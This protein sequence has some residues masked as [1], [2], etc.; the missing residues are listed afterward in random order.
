[1]HETLRARQVAYGVAGQATGVSILLR[2]PLWPVIGDHAPFMTFFPAVMLSA[3]LGG[4]GPGLVATF[5]SAAASAFF[6]PKPHFS[7]EVDDP[8]DV[9]A[10]GL[11]TLTGVV[12]SALSESLHRSRRRI[13]ASERRYAVTLASIGDAVLA[14]DAQA[15]VTFLNPTAEALTGWPLADAVGRPLAEVFRIVNEQTR[16]PVEDPAAKVFRTGAAVGLA[17]HTALLARDGRVTPIDDCAAPII[18]ERGG[19]GG[20]VLVFRDVTRR[21]RAEEAEVFRAAYERL[22][23]AVRGSNVGVWDLELPDGDYNR[24][25]RL[26]VNIWEQLGYDGPPPGR[27]SALDKADPDDRAHLEDTVRRYLAGETAEFEG[28]NRLRHKDGSYRTMLARGTAVRDA[29]GKPIRIA[30]VIIDITTLKLTEEALRASEQRF[31]T[32]VDHAADAF[33]LFDDQNIVLD[34][35]RQACE[36]LGRTRDELLG[37]TPIDFDPDVTPAQLEAMNHKLNDGQL[38]TFES[39]HRRKDGTVFPVEV[40]GQAFWEGGRRFTVSLARDNTER[41]RAEE[42]LRVSEAQYRSLADL[43]PGVVW[44]AEPDGAVDYAN[45]FW[46]RYTGL[47]PEQTWG[48]GWGAALHPDDLR[49]VGDLWT[50]ALRTGEPIGVEYRVRRASDGAYRWFLAWGTPVRDRDG[51]VVKWFGTGTDIDDQKRAEAELRDSQERFRGTFENAAVGIAHVD[52]AGRF[53]R[54]NEK[55]CA[56][57]GYSREELFQRTYQ[58]ITHPD[59]LATSIDVTAAMWRG[60]SSSFGLEKRYVRKDGLPVWVELFVSLQRDAA[61]A[62]AYDIAIIHDITERK[63]LEEALRA[64]EERYRFLT[65]S[66]PQK[67]FTANANGDVDYLNRQWTEFTGLSFDQI[68]GWGWLQ[69]IHPDDVDENVRQWQHSIDTGEPFQLEHR[70]RRADGVYRWHLSRALA[71]RD[72]DGRV[73]MWFGSNTDIDDQKRVAEAFR[74]AKEAAETANRAKDEFLANVSHEIRTPMTAILGMTELVLDTPLADDQRQ[75][76]RTVKSAADNLLGIINDL[77]DFAK[78]E[79][80]RLDL[81]LGDFSL[82]STVG[83]TLRALAARAHRKGLEVFC[84]VQPDVPDALIGDAGRLRQVVLNLVG[85]AIKFTEKGEVVVQVEGEAA[86]EPAR[87]QEVLLRF[88]VRDTGIGIPLDQQERIFRAFEQQDTSTTRRYGGTGL[89]LTIAARLVALMGGQITVDSAPHRGS[90][91]AFTACFG[92]QPHPAEPTAAPPALLRNLPVLI[93]DDNATNRQI[94]LEWLRGWQMDPAA[95]CDGVAAM[96]ALWEAAA[97]GRPYA[98]ILLDARMPDTDG[99]ALAAQIRKR[100]ELSV[101]RI[102]LLSSG[103]RPGDWDRVRALRIDGH[104]LKPIQQDEL[105]DRIYQVMTRVFVSGGVVSGEGP[106]SSGMAI[107][108]LATHHSTFA[109]PHILLAEDDEFSARYMEQLLARSGHRVRLT[110]NGRE[111]LALAEGGGFDLLQLDIHMPQLDGFGVVGAIRERERATRGALT[112]HRPDR[113]LPKGGPRALPRGRHGR[114]PDQAGCDRGPARGHRPAGAGPSSEVGRQKSEVRRRCAADLGPL[115]S[116]L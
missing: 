64:S 11:F 110:T 71:M 61:G 42:A 104:L 43:S 65:Q 101:T 27:E 109:N 6:L 47:T 95:A 53:L 50:R 33:F 15:R 111:A 44:T 10:L 113:T 108:G 115:A 63:R 26:Y 5:G 77:L 56:I 24:R 94:L 112:R 28:E 19:I 96:D 3:Y 58:E 21:R 38:M 22:E 35:N 70:F 51:R 52:G 49:R 1:M 8:A 55:F 31:R 82:R 106:L 73:L 46:F 2:W 90:T 72:A 81:D 37:M 103:D 32:F 97:R 59:D 4:L 12:L 116:D 93:I 34:V 114:L 41:N 86:A 75:C 18:D 66:I 105:L 20:V 45:P 102:L 9:L 99:L 98:L 7:F 87:P 14:T 13:L 54:V 79:A 78:I 100:A 107:P 36:S 40:R 83:N 91:F 67:V 68:K 76:L 29:A 23:L 92:L 69:F 62:P 57:V 74:Q 80:G 39:R 60:E 85:N 84:N 48:W 16:Q 89:G 17:N 88:S 25:R 30:G